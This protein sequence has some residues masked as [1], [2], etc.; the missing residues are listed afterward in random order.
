MPIF[1]PTYRQHCQVTCKPDYAGNLRRIARWQQARRDGADPTARMYSAD[2]S[3]IPTVPRAVLYRRDERRK[4][5]EEARAGK[6][7]RLR[8]GVYLRPFTRSGRASKDAEVTVMR[9]V[10]GVVDVSSADLWFSHTTA[11]L[12]HRCWL[13]RASS[14]V[15]VTYRVKPH[16]AI[17]TGDDV[18]KHWTTLTERDRAVVDGIPVTALERTVVDCA[19]LLSF[20]GGVVVATSAFRLGA[21]PAVV[22]EILDEMGGTRGIVKAR[23][24]VAAVEPG[25]ASPGEALAYQGARSLRPQQPETQVRVPT[26]RG[27]YWVD[28]GWSDLKIGFEFN[29]AVKLSGGSFGDPDVRR[30][31]QSARAQALMEEGWWIVD[32][33]WDDVIDPERLDLLMRQ[34]FVDRRRQHEK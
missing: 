3:D 28:I 31:D 17:E 2:R 20:D 16:T 13:Y 8:R 32:L 6:I 14:T 22:G 33:A 10:R 7:D 18:R 19:R 12:L 30:Q 23:E 11:A 21:D 15:H 34:V 27:V 24:V 26:R 9:G 5:A 25:C 29:G 4:L 1:E